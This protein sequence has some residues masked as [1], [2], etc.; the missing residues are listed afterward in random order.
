MKNRFITILVVTALICG[1]IAVGASANEITTYDALQTAINQYSGNGE[2]I[3]LGA[4]ITGEQVLTISQDT[5]LDLNGFDIACHI[6]VTSGTLYCMDSQ[7]DDYTIADGVYGKL[8]GQITGKIAGVPTVSKCSSNG[9]LPVSEAEGISFHCVNLQIYAAALRAENVGIYLKSH[10]AG[11]ELVAKSVD[12]FGI[13]LSVYETPNAQNLEGLC[14]R[15]VFTGFS[16]GENANAGD[17]TSTLL[18]NI[19]KTEN[20][21]I[22]NERNSDTTIYG[23]AYIETANGYVFGEAQQCTLKQ[24]IETAASN[25]AGCWPSYSEAQKA[26]AVSLYRNYAQIL[27]NWDVKN[28]ES[29]L[30]LN[31]NAPLNDGKTLKL[32]AITS[33]FGVNT[34]QLLYDVAVAQGYDP[35]N[36]I[37]GRLYASGCTLQKHLQHA[38]DKPLYRYTKF[39]SATDGKMLE[40]K[41]E[42]TATLLD[43]LQDENWDVIFIQQGAA[44]SPL[45]NSYVDAQGNDRVAQL[46]AIV[47]EYK[48]NPDAKFVWNMVWAYQSDSDQDV[49]VNHFNSDQMYMYQRNVD[50]VMQYVVPK[51]DFDRIIPSG[52]AIQNARTSYFGDRL[53]QDT[54]HANNLGGAIAAYGLFSVVTGQKV[55]SVN[56][57]FA[58]V[59]AENLLEHKTRPVL[60][61]ADKLVIMESIN[62]ALANPFSVTESSYPPEDYSDYN[63]TD[64]VKF[65]DDNNTA[66]CPACQMK[67]TWL[68][69][70]Q[71][72]YKTYGFGVAPAVTGTDA[73]PR[74]VYHFYLSE[75]IEHAATIPF[76]RSLYGDR[77][78]CLHLNGHNLTSTKHNVAE[79]GS[80]TKLNIM[81]TGTVCGSTYTPD[82]NGS[83]LI[84]NSSTVYNPGTI[85]LYSGTYTQPTGKAH[86]AVISTGATG[87]KLEIY[88]DATIIAKTDGYCFYSNTTN[89]NWAETINIYGGSFNRPFNFSY[90]SDALTTA[91]ALNIYGGTFKEGLEILNNTNATLSG[92][93]QI[94]G[95]G[96]KL[97]EGITI[98]LGELTEGAAI[99]VG[100]T[101][102]ISAPCE[103]VKDYIAYFTTPGMLV[104][105]KD[106]ALYAERD[107]DYVPDSVSPEGI[108][109]ALKFT[110]GSKAKCPVCQTEVVWTPITQEA[111]GE[112]APGKLANGGHYYL[113]EDITY[114]GIAEFA[115][116]PSSTNQVSCFHLNGHNLSATE[117]RAFFGSGGIL[118]VMGSGIVTGGH[119]DN[120]NHGAAV[121]INT[122]GAYGTINL[123]SGTY[124]KQD[125]CTASSVVYINANGGKINMFKDV[126]I[127]GTSGAPAVNIV[128]AQLVDAVMHIDGATIQG[129]LQLKVAD[130]RA[131]KNI[132]VTLNNT[133]VDTVSF[134]HNV[135]LTVA[136]NTIINKLDVLTGGKFIIEALGSKAKI[137]VAGEGVLSE[138]STHLQ[139][140]FNRF[141]S[142][143]GYQLS[144]VDDTLVS[145]KAE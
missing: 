95:A 20:Q 124:T 70:N 109:D 117:N 85:R 35:D 122:G 26:E 59:P 123:Y 118:N 25:N 33:S 134:N 60:T 42:G 14:D 5:Y 138:A 10:F 106:N 96:L 142:S 58:N 62:N 143:Y 141:T 93:P 44:N 129:E 2:A 104:T 68:E 1:I 57:D 136:G 54:Y 120:P 16:A 121:G 27:R 66:V 139:R 72:N 125:Y 112:T 6:N 90:A 98:T 135:S 8:S 74:G 17:N 84:I 40:V 99:T 13:A 51:A 46:K 38:P 89:K 64:D 55:T 108:T 52:T 119:D 21:Q 128:G 137:D 65:L 47:D 48:T 39:S 71:A 24:L 131:V 140:C 63:F 73:L 133:T 4:D 92:S 69:L 56:L 83:T 79:I 22:V 110:D 15:S 111:Y 30:V 49:F 23:R 113:A 94:L 29:A 3:I 12:T 41:K 80:N 102:V 76:F 116:A 18:F 43:G 87:G 132:Q 145:V 127:I 97:G 88:K 86:P 77:D 126:T 31:E 81:G 32:L 91:T 19:M 45:L 28:I 67:V 105:A 115:V 103:N 107:L 34:T 144:V 130:S 100:S 7:T 50:A 101:G 75:D 114:T 36:V 61:D 82:N 9:Y 11:D 53:C 78:V 37:V